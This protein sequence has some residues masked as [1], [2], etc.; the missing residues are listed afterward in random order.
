MLSIR[1][2]GFFVASCVLA[3]RSHRS[4]LLSRETQELL[5]IAWR[6]NSSQSHLALSSVELPSAW[7]WCAGTGLC[8]AS[9][10]QHIPQYCGSCWAHGTLSALADRIKIDRKG[11]GPDVNLAVQHVL[12]CANVGSCRGGSLDGVYQWL[13]QHAVAYE[14]EQPYLAC[15]PDSREGFCAHVD[16]TCSPVN[17]ARTC[18]GFTQEGGPCTGLTRYPNATVSD[19]GS[20]SGS[21]AM[22]KEIHARGPIAC[23]V[24]ASPLLNYEG[25]VVSDPGEFVD[26]VVEVTGWGATE[27]GSRYWVVRNSWGEYWG[28]MGFVRVG[29]G[30]LQIEE[31]CSWAVPGAYTA[32]ERRNYFPCH[33]GGDNC[34]AA[35][36]V[37]V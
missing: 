32:A 33:E 6:G 7:D 27:E 31:Q 34:R 5:G 2:A 30:S 18:G 29:F 24:D 3:G 12:N 14:T 22:M 25:G 9:R 28:E 1:G 13:S 8:T 10:N 26:H 16:S 21:E 4:E 19:Y 15:S 36:A 20:I 11:Y 35:P 23:G 17:T 37:L